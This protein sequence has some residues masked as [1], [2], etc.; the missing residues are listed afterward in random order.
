MNISDIYVFIKTY[1]KENIS[2][3]MDQKNSKISIPILKQVEIYKLLYYN[4]LITVS[5]DKE[6][7]IV[8]KEN[9]L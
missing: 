2:S 1:S 5:S 8:Q 6:I 9:V 4:V 3:T 7:I